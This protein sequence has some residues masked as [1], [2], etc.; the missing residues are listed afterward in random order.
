MVTEMN[1]SKTLAK[2]ISCECNCRFDEG[3]CSSHQL[4]NNDKC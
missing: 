2:H 1:L 3:K 4:W